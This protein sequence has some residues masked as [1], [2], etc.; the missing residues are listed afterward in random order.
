MN[1][2]SS[3]SRFASFRSL[4]VLPPCITW[5]VVGFALRTTAALLIAL[6]I[7]FQMDLDDPKWAAMTVWIVAQGS[8]GMSVSK[9]QY[10][11]A[12]TFIGAAVG[13]ALTAMFPQTPEIA[14]PLL[15]LWLGFCTALSTGLR[16]FRSY[17]AVLAGYTA[18]IVVMDS[19]SNPEDVF[20]IAVAR[21]TYI[22]LG[23]VVEAVM[24]MIFI[25]DDP[26]GDVRT[27]LGGFV[28]QSAG[29]ARWRCASRTPA[30]RFTN[31]SP[32]RSVSTA[33][34]NM[35]RLCRR[36]CAGGWAICERL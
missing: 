28:R 6:Y 13:I 20:N 34:R 35:R 7:A 4:I 12:G 30:R 10:R 31:C 32:A 29:F 2:G 19:V 22:G 15:A 21:V 26:V 8:R 36:N 5:P 11:F 27:E 33:R 3:P 18:V 9:G 16:N 17:G 25:T 23:I 1:S 24:A 14:L